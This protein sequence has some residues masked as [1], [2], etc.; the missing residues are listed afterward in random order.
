MYADDIQI[1]YSFH[2]EGINEAI[3]RVNQDLDAISE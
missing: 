1:Y 2:P 3:H